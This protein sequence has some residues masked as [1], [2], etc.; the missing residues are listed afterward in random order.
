MRGML[1]RAWYHCLSAQALCIAAS[2]VLSLPFPQKHVLRVITASADGG[3]GRLLQ[4]PSWWVH[5][6]ARTANLAPTILPDPHQS[7]PKR[8]VLPLLPCFTLRLVAFDTRYLPRNTT[9]G[10]FRGTPTR[11]LMFL[12]DC[13]RC[14]WNEFPDGN[15]L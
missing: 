10:I 12:W 6:N 13:R 2:V 7:R 8:S 9:L 5:E 15:V 3:A 4:K 11:L 1:K 14:L